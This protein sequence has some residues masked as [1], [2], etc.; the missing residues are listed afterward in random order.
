MNSNIGGRNRYPQAFRHIR[1][2]VRRGRQMRLILPISAALLLASCSGEVLEPEDDDDDI[3]A[4]VETGPIRVLI[5]RGH[6]QVGFMGT[7][8]PDSIVVS[9]VD[10]AGEP[11]SGTAVRFTPQGADASRRETGTTDRAGRVSFEWT[12]GSDFNQTAWA[13]HL[14][15]VG[16][17]D[18]ARVTATARYLYSPPS[19]G[20]GWTAGDLRDHGFDVDTLSVM[21][22][23]IRTQSFPQIHSVLIARGGEILLDE[24]FPELTA[25]QFQSQNRTNGLHLVASVSKSLTSTWLGI[26]VDQGLISSVTDSI[27]EFFPEYNGSIANWSTSKAGMTL[28]NVLTMQSGLGCAE[29]FSWAAT[30]DWVKHTLDLPLLQQPGT[31]FNYCTMLTHVLAAVVSNSSGLSV[32]EFAEQYMFDPMGISLVEWQQAPSGRQIMGYA[33]WMRPRDMLKFGQLVLNEGM[34]EGERIVSAEWLEQATQPRV[35][36]G[37]VSYG[38]QWWVPTLVRGSDTLDVAAAW[39]NG[40]QDIYAIPELDLTVVFTAGNYNSSLATIPLTLM[41]QFVIPAAP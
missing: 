35:Q 29:D 16:R 22:D 7:E 12:L 24:R 41:Q 4:P 31:T 28:E 37:S 8:L 14:P 27:Y 36:V 6:R 9:V 18:S 15:E 23:S 1:V 10:G 26:A 25:P 2:N 5:E 11:V 30:N 13:T 39:G 19:D 38:Y 21:I 20:E 40:G 3:P 34:W 33:F 17:G 32:R